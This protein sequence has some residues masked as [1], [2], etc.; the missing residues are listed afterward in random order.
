M[1]EANPQTQ[2]ATG[3]VELTQ[4]DSLLKKEFKPK[5]DRAKDAI[6]TAVK[7]LAEQAL[8]STTLISDDAIKTIESIIAEIDRKLSQQLNQILHN[9][10]F[11]RLEGTWRGLHYMV[12]NTE[13]D[14]FLKIRVL[15][16]T[17][18]DLAK[19]QEVQGFSVGPVP[20]LQE[21]LRGGVR[22]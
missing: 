1:P 11:Q 4:F 20:G 17:K 21:T 7:T 10:D 16:V 22:L 15:N 19:T 13:T 8:S 2:A 9:P 18:K 3:T 5:T 6:E 12:S 14:E